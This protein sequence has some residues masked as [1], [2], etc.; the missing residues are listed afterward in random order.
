[1]TGLTKARERAE[2]FRATVKAGRDPLYDAKVTADT[3]Q[4]EIAAKA[5]EA[6]R[7]EF[8]LDTAAR[9]YHATIAPTFKNEKHAR[10]WLS[11]LEN[12][13]FPRLPSLEAGAAAM[14]SAFSRPALLGQ[15]PR[16]A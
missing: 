16:L 2:S 14:M 4:K 15:V 13:V 3:T 9:D 5:A 10:Q 7:A 6:K 12:H 11:S 1:M 8:T